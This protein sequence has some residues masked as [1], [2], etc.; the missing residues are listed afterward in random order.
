[1][2]KYGI[3]IIGYKNV[4]GVSRLLS[5]LDRVVFDEEVMLIFSIDHSG[6]RNVEELAEEYQW[7]HGEK[8]VI[9]YE[10]NLGLKKHILKCGDYIEQ[11]SLDAMAVLED[12]IYV[13]PEFFHYMK[14]T[15][16]W[17]SN[18][19]QIA[20]ISLY[21]HEYNIFAKHPF[22]DYDD[23]GDV[24]FMQYAMSWGQI[25]LKKQWND[26]KEWYEADQWKNM[27]PDKIPA[28]VLRW[29][30]SW[31][32][33]HIMYCI[34]KDKYFVFPRKSLT[35]NFT[36]PGIHNKRSNTSMQVPLNQKQVGGWHFLDLNET[37]AVYDAFFENV[38]LKA[39]LNL[40]D[41]EVD[42]YGVKSVDKRKKYLLTRKILP[43]VV[44]KSWGMALR[45]IEANI[46]GKIDG[47]DIFLYNTTLPA[48]KKPKVDMKMRM[49]EYDLKG[50]D[51]VNFTT[52]R[53]CIREIIDYIKLKMKK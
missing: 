18:N 47:K 6:V 14:E 25:W 53:F 33:Y 9:A 7:V 3:T 46:F 20:G 36:D 38:G 23:G 10:Q 50:I 28:N 1:M 40:E 8:V 32:K 52:V 39:F 4:E 49:L 13:S 15:V 24:F 16:L 42:L 29:D 48:E 35:T 22:I 51:I 41:V 26:F 31:L 2:S 30:K 34:D 43:Y 21:K 12:D 45:P 27:D 19:P 17:F 37:K 11:Y 5:S 44:E